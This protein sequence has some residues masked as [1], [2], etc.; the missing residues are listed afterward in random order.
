LPKW[1]AACLGV[2]ALVEGVGF[3][4]A[5][6]GVIVIGFALVFVGAVMAVHAAAEPTSELVTQP[7]H[8]VAV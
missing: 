5:S 4:S 6:K 1:A 3:A 7:A 2:G 8:R